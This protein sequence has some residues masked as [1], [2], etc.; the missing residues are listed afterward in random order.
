MVPGAVPTAAKPSGI[1][2]I[3][4]DDV[5]P[6][7]ASGNTTADVQDVIDLAYHAK[8]SR[9][10]QPSPSPKRPRTIRLVPELLTVALH[11]NC[12]RKV[13]T[14]CYVPLTAS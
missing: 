8:Y 10:D 1:G 3:R 9:Y 2:R 4:A 5:E 12:R 7:L 14:A 6:D 13:I 11:R